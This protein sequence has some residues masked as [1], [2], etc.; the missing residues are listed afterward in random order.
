MIL[1]NAL[2]IIFAA[3]I[4]AHYSPIKRKPFNCDLCLTFWISLYYFYTEY[5]FQYFIVAVYSL[6][7]AYGC[8][9]F[10]ELKNK[11]LSVNTGT[12]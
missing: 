7:N 11:F 3:K 5:N 1:F 8:H 6:A 10:E 12:I 4:L 2:C 9:L